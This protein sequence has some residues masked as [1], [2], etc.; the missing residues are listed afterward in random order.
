MAR[1]KDEDNDRERKF[2]ERMKQG[3][4]Q[5]RKEPPR[6]DVPYHKHVEEPDDEDKKK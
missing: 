6:D 3:R 4:E 5:A 1:N 2:Q